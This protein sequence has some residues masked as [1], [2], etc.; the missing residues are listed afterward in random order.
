MVIY[1]FRIFSLIYLS[2]NVGICHVR[3][4]GTLFT[5][6]SIYFFELREFWYEN[7]SLQTILPV[8]LYS[9]VLYYAYFFKHQYLLD[10]AWVWH[11]LRAKRIQKR[12]QLCIILKNRTKQNKN[13]TVYKGRLDICKN[14]SDKF[15]T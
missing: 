12:N 6:A 5:I 8:P 13:L 4:Q 10:A 2:V 15:T 3:D 9:L 11:M 7:L 14:K 1:C